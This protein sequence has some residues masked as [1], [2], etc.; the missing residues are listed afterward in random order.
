MPKEDTQLEGHK[1]PFNACEILCSDN[2][3]NLSKLLETKEEKPEEPEKKEDKSEE[4]EEKK[5][6]DDEKKEEEEKKEEGEEKK[7]GE[8]PKGEEKK[9]DEAKEEEKKEEEKKEDSGKMPEISADDVFGEDDVE[10]KTDELKE[11]KDEEEDTFNYPLM[12]K[13]LDYLF[14]F[15]EIPPDDDNYVLMGYFGKIVGYLFGDNKSDTIM[16]YLIE[17]RKD[18]IKKMIPH[19]DRKAI[20]NI[21]ESIIQSLFEI[22]PSYC[23]IKDFN[24]D[25]S[26]NEICEVLL[27][28]LK[29]EATPNEGIEIICETLTNSMI[30]SSKDRFLMLLSSETLTKK[31][32]EAVA[33]L[34]QS[35]DKRRGMF[36]IKMMNKLTDVAIKDVDKKVT[37]NFDFAEA[38]NEILSIIRTISKRG[39]SNEY[40]KPWNATGDNIFSQV[41]EKYSKFLEPI[42]AAVIEDIMKTEINKEDTFE[43][44]YFQSQCKINMKTLF[45]WEFIRSILDVIVN[46]CNE[47]DGTAKVEALTKITS[48][49]NIFNKLLEFY[50][51]YSNCNMFQNVFNQIISILVN[52]LTPTPLVENLLLNK[53]SPEKSLTNLLIE[54][55]LKNNEFVYLSSNKMNSMNFG[56]D[57]DALKLIA[58][59]DNT[60][61]K[62]ILNED[63]LGR[64]H[65]I[66]V[67]AMSENINKKLLYK[68]KTCDSIYG[69]DDR[70]ED[71]PFSVVSN[72][73]VFDFRMKLYDMALKGEDYKEVE[74]KEEERI[75]K[76]MTPAEPVQEGEDDINEAE[77]IKGDEGEEE[78]DVDE[79]GARNSGI[80]R[81]N[82]E[83][84]ENEEREGETETQSESQ[85]EDSFNDLN[86][87]NN[88]PTKLGVGDEVLDELL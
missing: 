86:Y 44:S 5:E 71:I 63:K 72:K 87:W 52:K 13:I 2:G 15:L 62:E 46:E 53:E 39:Q 73:N 21:I 18:I 3:L 84:E 88:D 49:K 61:I 24:L 42:V 80:E 37:P 8:E 64:F 76:L 14:S 81:P 25:Q 66:V 43:N 85:P 56:N 77:L 75:A 30:T 4:E 23:S 67:N 27:D 12:N 17:T 20:G 51:F 40:Q 54:S 82:E 7:E 6:E 74:K 47:D 58:T 57:I 31:F 59:S 16:K 11:E 70:D 65:E 1:Y 45:E 78:V 50:Q 35:E 32:Q 60:R 19:I 55:I 41:F 69:R 38:E 68:E 29:C 33:I 48:E 28:A 26:V 22:D 34:I 79:M 9:E 36:A 83:N 10:R